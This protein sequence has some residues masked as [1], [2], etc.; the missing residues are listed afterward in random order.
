M[1][2]CSVISPCS[3]LCSNKLR[4]RGQGTQDKQPDGSRAVEQEP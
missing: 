3:H 1:L 4:A 2:A